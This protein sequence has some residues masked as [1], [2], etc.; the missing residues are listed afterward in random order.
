MFKAF[1]ISVL[2]LILFVVAVNTWLT[3]VRSTDWDHS[4]YLKVYP[5]NADGSPAAERYIAG[6]TEAS[7]TDVERFM[8]REIERYGHGLERPLR[9]TLG[10]PVQSQPPDPAAAT[11]MLGVMAWSL[12]L[13]WWARD[14]AGPQDNP[15]PDVRMFVRYH[16]PDETLRLDNSVG[17]QKGMVGIVNGYASRR[18]QGYNNLVIA[19]E[20][21]HTLGASDKYDLAN[22]QPVVPEGLAEPGREPLYPQRYAEIMAGR[23]A[24]AENVADVPKNLGV[25]LIGPLTA[26]EI[27]L[28]DEP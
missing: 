4:L 16:A 11:S 6:L 17:L 9:V 14:V 8:Q 23:I 19:H 27:G 26:S 25:V 10:E 7:F 18:M 28:R 20:F 24:Y 2:L 3:Q 15:R 21:L 22:G 5:I 13:R 12:K 1:R